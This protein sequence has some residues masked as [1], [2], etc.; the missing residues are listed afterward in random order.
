MTLCSLVGTRTKASAETSAFIFRV[1]VEG[2]RKFSREWRKQIAPRGRRLSTR[3]HG[4]TSQ[5]TVILA[6]HASFNIF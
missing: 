6:V 2:V 4:V 5:K 3:I 1:E